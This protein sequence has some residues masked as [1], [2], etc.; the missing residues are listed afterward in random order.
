MAGVSL[1]DDALRSVAKTRR[2]THRSQISQL[3]LDCAPVLVEC[4]NL[5]LQASV[6]L[7]RLSEIFVLSDQRDL[8]GQAVLG[9]LTASASRCLRDSLSLCNLSWSLRWTVSS[10]ASIVNTHPLL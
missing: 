10:L 4:V 9:G 5:A 2:R 1:G 8:A 6:L 3:F 7:L